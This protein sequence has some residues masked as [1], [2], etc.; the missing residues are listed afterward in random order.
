[1]VSLPAAIRSLLPV[2]VI[3][4]VGATIRG[5]MPSTVWP[6]SETNGTVKDAAPSVAVRVT[7]KVQLLPV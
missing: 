2:N 5:T 7:L 3:L 4:E 6:P 1:M